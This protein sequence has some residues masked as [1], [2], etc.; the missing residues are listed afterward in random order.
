ME[1]PHLKKAEFSFPETTP[2]VGGAPLGR[3]KTLAGFGDFGKP[4]WL[5]LWI[6][7]AEPCK[8]LFEGLVKNMSHVT[9][10]TWVIQS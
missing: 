2:L 3:S 4:A 1:E 8:D 9:D 5:L 10:P 6:W 7:Q